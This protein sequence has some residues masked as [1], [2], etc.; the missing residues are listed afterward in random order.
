L[1][2]K[3]DAGR[4]HEWVRTCSQ[5]SQRFSLGFFPSFS[6]SSLAHEWRYIPRSFVIK[7]IYSLS[8]YCRLM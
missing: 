5:S 4:S 2:N 7:N 6:S 1:I 3:K 8:S